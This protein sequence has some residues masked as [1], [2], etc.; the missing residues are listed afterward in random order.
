MKAEMKG[1][2]VFAAAVLIFD[3]V[4][5]IMISGTDSEGARLV[6]VPLLL[7][8]LIFLLTVFLA[9]GKSRYERAVQKGVPPD[10]TLR[11]A[12]RMNDTGDTRA[13]GILAD[14]Y[15]K[16][17][18]NEDNEEAMVQT[19]YAEAP[20]PVYGSE[21][22]D[23]EE[24]PSVPPV[25]KAPIGEEKR[26]EPPRQRSAGTVEVT[27]IAAADAVSFAVYVDGRVVGYIGSVTSTFSVPSGMHEMTIF[28][29]DAEKKQI[30]KENLIFNTNKNIRIGKSVRKYSV[31]VQ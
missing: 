30:Y 29:N 15:R 25:Q 18:G 28:T 12:I 7:F 26:T 14:A 20:V 6:I 24:G 3:I 17:K 31:T 21:A 10:M 11:E 9:P 1:K 19:P 4:F 5:L 22:Q 16:A 27:G 13:S 23:R 8:T 2:V